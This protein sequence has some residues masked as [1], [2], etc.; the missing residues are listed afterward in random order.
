MDK[1]L[2]KE[3]KLAWLAQHGS[4][5]GVKWQRLKPDEPPT[6]LV[7][8]NGGEFAAIRSRRERRKASGRARGE[9]VFGLYSVG[10]KTNRDDVVYD[11]RRGTSFASA[12]ADF[13]DALQCARWTDIERAGG[14]A[15]IDEFVRYDKIKWSESLKANLRRERY[16]DFDEGADPDGCLYRPFTKRSLCFNE[17]LIERRYQFAADLSDSPTETREHA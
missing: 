10:V 4:I 2:R 17:F 13:V 16:A 11:F 9:A 5:T 14:K 7:P 6:W 12:S 1:T 3:H 8:V 15:D